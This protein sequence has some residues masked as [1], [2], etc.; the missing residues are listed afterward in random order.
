MGVLRKI[1]LG[2]PLLA[3][4]L[5]RASGQNKQRHRSG[6]ASPGY[7]AAYKEKRVRRLGFRLHGGSFPPGDGVVAIPV[8]TCTKSRQVHVYRQ[9]GEEVNHSWLAHSAFEDQSSGAELACM[10]RA[11]RLQRGVRHQMGWCWRYP[12]DADATRGEKDERIRARKEVAREV[13]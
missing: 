4:A 9:A 10:W 1:I 5:A 11:V 6:A 12:N 13:H 2:A 3:L 7:L 8:E